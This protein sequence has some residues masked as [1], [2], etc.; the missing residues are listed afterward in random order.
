[1]L[2]V[3]NIV[4]EGNVKASAKVKSLFLLF[5]GEVSV[6]WESTW[7]LITWQKG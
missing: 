2:D 3:E 6:V 1:M 5:G 4:T 7:N